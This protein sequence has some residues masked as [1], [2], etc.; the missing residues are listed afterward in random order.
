MTTLFLLALATSGQLTL[1]ASAPLP[2]KPN[3]DYVDGTFWAKSPND[4]LVFKMHVIAPTVVEEVA[5]MRYD[6]NEKSVTRLPG[7]L[8]FQESCDDGIATLYTLK[9]NPQ[10][11][12]YDT[13]YITNIDVATGKEL[14]RFDFQI[15]RVGRLALERYEPMSEPP[16]N[17]RPRLFDVTTGKELLKVGRFTNNEGYIGRIAWDDGKVRLFATAKD[18]DGTLREGF[19]IYRA[20]GNGF[21]RGPGFK[22]I[23]A[24]LGFDKIVGNPSETYFAVRFSSNRWA[25]FKTYTRDYAET[26]FQVDYIYD[27]SPLGVLGRMIVHVPEFGDPKLGK[28]GCWNP[29]TGELLWQT[30]TK[31]NEKVVW[32]DR[33]ALTGTEIRNPTTGEVVANLPK[34]RIFASA[35]GN[36]IWLVTKDSPSNLE[37]WHID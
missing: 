24:S 26:T 15:E 7:M 29:M 19:S 25:S 12:V 16:G 3:S 36:T 5:V 8:G 2:I 23:T 35:R 14:S 10:T 32:L 30:E 11:R 37:V 1:V 4:S 9:R 33:Y 17:T 28:L 6:A 18:K 27:V 34:D 13:D 22:V 31:E 21:E 20:E